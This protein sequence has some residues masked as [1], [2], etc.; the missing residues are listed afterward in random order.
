MISP[1]LDRSKMRQT[2]EFCAVQ[3][4][5]PQLP[6]EEMLYLTLHLLGSRVNAVSPG[7]LENEQEIADLVRALVSEFEKV[8][9][10]SFDQRRSLEQSR[11]AKRS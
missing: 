2:H 4:H 10:I 1:G 11:R 5:F 7:L 8:A 3:A 6:E 9:C